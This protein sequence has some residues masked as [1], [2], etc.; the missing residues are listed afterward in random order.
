MQVSAGAGGIN[1]MVLINDCRSAEEKWYPYFSNEAHKLYR[2][3][4]FSCYWWSP[5]PTRVAKLSLTCE[6]CRSILYYSVLRTVISHDEI[7]NV[8]GIMSKSF[9]ETYEDKAKELKRTL[10]EYVKTLTAL[11]N[12]A[13]ATPAASSILF[14]GDGEVLALQIGLFYHT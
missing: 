10:L 5:T 8:L 12:S 13:G 4:A 2:E 6:C 11:T 14:D 7:A 1:M 9:E 3:M